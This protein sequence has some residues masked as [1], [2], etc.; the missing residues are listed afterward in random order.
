MGQTAPKANVR[1][2]GEEEEKQEIHTTTTNTTIDMI[3]AEFDE[4]AWYAKLP[5]TLQ[6]SSR[7][8][9]Q[10]QRRMS[11]KPCLLGCSSN[12]NSDVDSQCT[13]SEGLKQSLHKQGT[14]IHENMIKIHTDRDI[15]RDFDGFE[16][17]TEANVLGQ[18]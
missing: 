13:V 17:L 11:G 1:K 15:R 7:M 8:S 3:D 5:K 16:N 6:D 9:V 2:E 12:S 18:G 14:S 4:E 10:S